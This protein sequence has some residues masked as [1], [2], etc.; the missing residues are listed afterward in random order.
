M[1]ELAREGIT[2]NC[3]P[4]GRINSEQILERLVQGAVVSTFNRVIGDAEM[5]AVV[6][7]FMAAANEVFPGIWPIDFQHEIHV[8]EEGLGIPLTPNLQYLHDESR[9]HSY[10]TYTH[11]RAQS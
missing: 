4:P 3:I 11:L 7:A 8:E 9:W 2:V 1:R 6:D 10:V 5:D